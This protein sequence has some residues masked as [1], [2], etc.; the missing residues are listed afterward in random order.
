MYIYINTYIV[1]LTQYPLLH[2]DASWCSHC[3]DLAPTWETL[4]EVMEAAAE[5]VVE[6]EVNRMDHDWTPQDFEQAKK[7]EKPVVIGKVDCVDHKELC[8]KYNIRAYPSDRK[9]VV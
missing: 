1:V 3:R 4:A 2:P 8:Q 6:A 9:S 7:L 5:A